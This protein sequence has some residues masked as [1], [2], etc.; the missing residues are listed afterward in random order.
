MPG[1]TLKR[2]SYTYYCI[3]LSGGL[4]SPNDK[5]SGKIIQTNYPTSNPHIKEWRNLSKVVVNMRLL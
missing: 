4:G 1:I 3:W 5:G 2:L